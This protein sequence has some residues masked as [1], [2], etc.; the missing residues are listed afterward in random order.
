MNRLYNIK[1]RK[2]PEK[3]KT[4]ENKINNYAQLNSKDWLLEKLAQLKGDLKG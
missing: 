3:I 2:T 4:L 1:E